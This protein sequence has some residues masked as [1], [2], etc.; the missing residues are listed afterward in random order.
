[1][2]LAQDRVQLP[3]FSALS[4]VT[5]CTTL[6]MIS[7]CM[8]ILPVKVTLITVNCVVYFLVSIDM[9]YKLRIFWTF[10]GTKKNTHEPL[11]F[12]HKGF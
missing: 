6:V 4:E 2:E 12:S 11:W 8:T 10:N 3:V 7:L 9:E 5:Y 1:M